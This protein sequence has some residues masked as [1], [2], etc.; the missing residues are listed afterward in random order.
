MSDLRISGSSVNPRSETDIRL[1]YGDPSKL[2]AASN[3]GGSSF[4][5]AM[6]WSADGGATWN[7]ATLPL[8]GSDTLQ[9]DP[10][11]DWTSD[12]TAWAAAIGIAG[13]NTSVR[14]Y[15]STNGGQTW[16]F[17]GTPSGSQTATDREV[18][19]V[20]H[21]PT[22]PFKDQIYV[23]W[24]NGQP[25]FVA[26]RTPGAGG[27]WQAPVQVTGAETT[28]TAIGD[29]VKTN[30]FGDVFAFWPDNAGSRKIFVAKSVN[31]GVS[32]GTPVQIGSIFA[33]TRILDVPADNSRGARVYVSG[34]AFRTAAKNMAYCL[35][36]DLSGE[37]SCTSGSGPG[38]SVSSS[39]KT[40]I[41]LARSTDGGATWSAAAMLNNQ[42]SKSD[43]FHGRLCV[44][45]SSGNLMAVYYD[46]VNDP[47]R[48]KTDVWMQSSTDD[49]QTWSTAVQVTS[50]QTD[51][52]AP[53][54]DSGNQYGDYIGLSGFF[55]NFHPSWTDRRS[56]GVE[57]IWSSQLSL[58]QQDC[59]F[60]VEKST[61]GQDEVAAMLHA[62][63][64]T[65]DAAFYVV[66]EGFSAAALGI[67]SADLVGAPTHK[68]TLGSIPTVSGMTIG[69]PTALLAEDP[70]L[71][72]TPQRFTWVYPIT[73]TSSTT[74]FSQPLTNVGLSATMAGVSGGAVIELVQQQ[75][76]YELDG[77]TPWLSTDLRVFHIKNGESKFGAAVGGS[78]P[79]DAISFIQHVISNLNPGGSSGGQTFEA[80]LDPNGTEVALNQT[81]GSGTAI[82][83][84]AIA[85]V[86]YR[87]LVQDAQAV[88]VFFRLCPALT[89]STA[90]EPTTTYR[91]HSDGVQFGSKIAML[92]TQNHNILTIPCFAQG[93]VTPGASMTT[94]TDPHN[95][96]PINHDS[97]GAEVDMYFGCWL[98]TN[99]PQAAQQMFPLNPVD[100]GPYSGSLK[101]VLE[102]VRNQH[103]CLIAEIAFDLDPI[104]TTPSPVT[105]F[106]SDKLAQRNLT[107]TPSANPGDVSSRR[108][109]NAFEFKPTRA[110]LA[111]LPD[112]LMI[113]W[114][115]V[116]VGSVARLYLPT[117]S[118]DEVI[119]LAAK[120]YSPVK[121]TRLDPHTIEFPVHRI[122]YVPV[123]AGAVSLNHTGLLTVDLPPGVRKGQR[124]DAVLRQL[125]LHGIDK[126]VP[127]VLEALGKEGSVRLPVWKQVLGTVQVGI[128]VDVKEALL[129]P[130]EHLFSLMQ[131]IL[132]SVP[133]HD[134]W[135][136][137]FHRYVSE[138]GQRVRGLGG[139]PAKVP[140]SPT[141]YWQH[142]GHKPEGRG[143]ETVVTF[144]GKVGEL[145]YDRFGDFEGFVLDTEDGDRIFR[146]REHQVEEVAK[147][148]WAERI[149]ITVRAERHAAER[150][151][152]I[153][154]RHASRPGQH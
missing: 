112:E 116:P 7:N 30:A 67:T 14:A 20:D 15:Q 136:P 130:E 125:T 58:V 140:P 142:P 56:G 72:S 80:D 34:G 111:R 62:G 59:Y 11:V 96:R 28:G 100:D 148:A 60:I 154:L 126:Q 8:A 18:M 71:P 51:E 47:G 79:A 92:G 16:I 109:P 36:T 103:Q 139:D 104:P 23:I 99:Q 108:I 27:S 69:D 37:A 31:G 76:P 57:E 143:G 55:G 4:Q 127:R 85:R 123:P 25:G 38:A 9:S 81:D 26:R 32:F 131:W 70:S 86:R 3:E 2:V 119:E 115:N 134:R 84:F 22:S 149:A 35:W 65:F 52:T 78:T 147:R 152:S 87:A 151:M 93:R 150:P 39:C 153:S 137:V 43:Q 124:F 101:T 75:D 5:Q 61:F 122:S 13:A 33:T 114:G 145:V 129:G 90:F 97:S 105:P 120:R 77:A 91:T 73:F 82:F 138:I 24:H 64:P 44:D 146:S 144:C 117:V 6:F 17:D 106:T 135:Y 63:T 68:P 141:G 110:V 50:A 128:P 102:L 113:D 46:T 66:V 95:V 89:V 12:G 98:D 49:G 29:D 21:S 74:P 54:A 107:L 83:N 121:Y 118:A 19:W 133:A 1:N 45:E 10:A 94:Q 40:R 88:R 132:K 41:W 48:L 42:S 53:G